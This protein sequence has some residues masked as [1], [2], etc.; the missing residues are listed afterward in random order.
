MESNFF[1]PTLTRK[2]RFL[3]NP[4]IHPKT[5]K[6]ITIGDVTYHK[7]AKKYGYPKIKSPVTQAK[8][9]IGKGT[10]NK[11]IKE[12]MSEAYLLSLL[13]PTIEQSTQST[14]EL[15][16]L[17]N[18]MYYEIMKHLKTHELLNL[19]KTNKNLN[20]YCKNKNLNILIDNMK[21]KVACGYSNTF[22]I[23]DSK[24]Y[25]IGSNSHGQI[26]IGVQSKDMV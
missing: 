3:H 13:N 11:L 4:T 19:C 17:P 2:Q 7:L 20:Q 26:G 8:I 9:A 24:L 14:N 1:D 10:Y 21:R 22:I 16:N 15:I 25:G 5:N 23:K 12:G 6:T 18:D